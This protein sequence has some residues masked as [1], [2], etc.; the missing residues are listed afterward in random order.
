[1]KR[2]DW[3]IASLGPGSLHAEG[4]STEEVR[5]VAT[6]RG[7]VH[8][9]KED[10]EESGGLLGRV[11]LELGMDLDDEG[12]GDGGEQTS[13]RPKSA[14]ATR[15]MCM[16]TNISVVFKSSSYFFMNSLSYSSASLR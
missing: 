15:A 5:R 2:R 3:R 13:L 1:V 12:R 4:Q 8:L 10:S 14:H 11:W 6:E 9:V 16:P 7:V